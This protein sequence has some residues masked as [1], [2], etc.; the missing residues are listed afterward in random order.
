M[1]IWFVYFLEIL[2]CYKTILLM[3]IGN[4]QESQR[5]TQRWR[6]GQF[7]G[8]DVRSEKGVAFSRKMDVQ[9]S[10][11]WG[12][13]RTEVPSRAFTPTDWPVLDQG[14]YFFNCLPSTLPFPCGC[15]S[16]HPHSQVHSGASSGEQRNGTWKGICLCGFSSVC[17]IALEEKGG[18]KAFLR[19]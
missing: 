14:N 12:A 6:E 3:R 1:H 13:G 11:V 16:S 9:L 4:P 15:G 2:P 5:K 17:G 8:I 7:G 19:Q 18:G 10:G